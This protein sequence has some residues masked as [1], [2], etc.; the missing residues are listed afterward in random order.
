M[1][2]KELFFLGS[3]EEMQGNQTCSAF[4]QENGSIA[5]RVRLTNGLVEKYGKYLW[6]YG[7]RFTYGEKEVLKALEAHKLKKGKALSFRLLKDA[8]GWRVFI[9]LSIGD[10]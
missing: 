4:L 6:L 3:H 9:S 1:E 7:I 8:K 5:L 10:F 2:A